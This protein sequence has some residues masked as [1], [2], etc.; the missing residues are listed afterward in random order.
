M[1]VIDMHV[2]VPRKPGRPEIEIEPHLREYFRVRSAP[3]TADEMAAQYKEWDILGAIFSVD[4]ESST[5]EG[6]D[7]ND[8]AAEIATRHHQQF[9]GFAT[10]DPLK[11]KAAV[12]EL[13]RAVTRLGLKGLKLQ[14]IHQAFFPNDQ[15]FYLCTRNVLSWGCRCCSTPGLPRRV[16]AQCWPVRS[17]LKTLWDGSLVIS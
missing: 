7:S 3:E 12:L 5:G 6:P 4:T 17:S 11:G 1:Q 10:V 9:I 15:R 2:H 8:Y 14:P 16:P 13:E